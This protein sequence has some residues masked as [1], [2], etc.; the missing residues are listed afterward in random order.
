MSALVTDWLQ[1]AHTTPIARSHLV[2]TR[3][4]LAPETGV[5]ITTKEMTLSIRRVV[6]IAAPVV[7]AIAVAACGSSSSSSGTPGGGGSATTG[8]GSSGPLNGAGSTLPAPLD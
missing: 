3:G 7:A 5:N 4:A 8:G 2:D 1:N 6:A